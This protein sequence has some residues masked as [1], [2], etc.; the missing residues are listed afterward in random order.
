MP[1]LRIRARVMLAAPLV[2][3]WAPSGTMPMSLA[4]IERTGPTT[5]G[6]SE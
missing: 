5:L 6:S 2:T 3:T 1:A 4:R